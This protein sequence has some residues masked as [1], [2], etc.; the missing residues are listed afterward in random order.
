V[1]AFYQ[2]ACLL[3]AFEKKQGQKHF[4]EANQTIVFLTFLLPILPLQGN[5]LSTG[6]A[7]L[8]PLL[9]PTGTN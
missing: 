1:L 8:S 6:G 2:S 7:A 5:I 4:A 3:Q 9:V